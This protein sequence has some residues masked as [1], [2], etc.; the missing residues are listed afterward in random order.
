MSDAPNPVMLFVCQHGAA[1]SVVAAQ[2]LSRL[3]RARGVEIECLSAGLEPDDSVPLHVI[4]GLADDGLEFVGTKPQRATQQLTER[5]NHIVS[6]G[7]DL[8]EVAMP[9]RV[10]VWND[11]PAVSDGYALARDAIVA[12]LEPLLDAI[13]SNAARD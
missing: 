10:I 8:T 6:F 12:R 5:A 2:H 1:K 13:L 4:A 7:C 3:A 9:E 11:V